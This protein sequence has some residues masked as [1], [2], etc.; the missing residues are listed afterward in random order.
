MNVSTCHTGQSQAGPSSAFLPHEQSAA[1]VE[2]YQKRE[3]EERVRHAHIQQSLDKRL[4]PEH[5]SSRPGPG[6]RKLH[7]LEGN[8]AI[9]IANQVWGYDGWSTEILDQQFDYHEMDPVTKRWSTCASATVKVILAPSLSIPGYQA[10]HTDVGTGDSTGPDRAQ[11]IALAR[12]AAVTD[13]T[14]RALRCFGELTGN[15][16]YDETFTKGLSKVAPVAAK[17]RENKYDNLYRGNDNLRP[18]PPPQAYPQE[19]QYDSDASNARPMITRSADSAVFAKPVVP[20][21]ARQA[22][23]VDACA[24]V[25]KAAPA[26][27]EEADFPDDES[28]FDQMDSD[29]VGVDIN[30]SMVLDRYQPAVGDVPMT[31]ATASVLPGEPKRKDAADDVSLVE[32]KKQEA[33]AKREAAR[34]RQAARSSTPVRTGQPETRARSSAPEGPSVS[35]VAAASAIKATAPISPSQATSG[36]ATARNLKRIQDPMVNSYPQKRSSQS[37]MPLSELRPQ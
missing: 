6:G 23:S 25:C 36:F 5:L 15:C 17:N 1:T 4:G 3:E 14:K 20:A 12:K 34:A 22:A 35:L 30:A 37:R 27:E 7:Y 18:P 9:G 31:R 19:S 2:Y 29:F 28:L 21:Y 16:C 13:A 10:Y 24:P 33:A 26:A 11:T 8:R 32:R